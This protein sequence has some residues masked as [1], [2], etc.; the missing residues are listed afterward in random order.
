MGII[1]LMWR[2]LERQI[3]MEP[4]V[5]KWGKEKNGENRSQYSCLLL[6]ILILSRYNN[7]LARSIAL[8]KYH[9]MMNSEEKII[10]QFLKDL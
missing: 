8:K 10:L 4:L 1:I 7:F 3:R 9:L 5:I 6:I 2:F